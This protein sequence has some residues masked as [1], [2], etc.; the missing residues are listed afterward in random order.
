MNVLK[1]RTL[2]KKLTKK[3]DSFV[4]A[5]PKDCISFIWDLTLELWS[6]RDKKYA[7]QRLQ[8]NITNIIKKQG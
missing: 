6:L 8:R 7:K 5:P 1:N 4:N 3:D 2:L